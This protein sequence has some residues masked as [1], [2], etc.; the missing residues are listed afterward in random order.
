ML[1]RLFLM[2]LLCIIIQPSLGLAKH[3]KK[4]HHVTFHHLKKSFHQKKL[5]LHQSS[6]KKNKLA[7]RKKRT[8]V[9]GYRPNIK[10]NQLPSYIVQS[11]KEQT[12]ASSEPT[13][14]FQ[15]R[16]VDFVHKSIGTIRYSVYKLGGSLFDPTKGVY[17]LDC[18]NYVDQ[19]LNTAH[20]ES[21]TN[22]VKS[23]GSDKPNS[24]DYYNFFSYL[25]RHP[26]PYWQKINEVNQMEPGDILVVR[27]KNNRGQETGGHV[28][29]VM[30]KPTPN[31]DAY[32]VDVADSAAGPHSQDTRQNN[33]SGIGIG[34]LLLKTLPH[35]D[36][37]AALA[38]KFGAHWQTNINLAIARPLDKREYFTI[39][40]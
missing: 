30:N 28:M 27:Y 18:S 32:Q 38:W 16:L 8:Y 39:G 3:S 11:M 14:S 5:V 33:V 1:K 12:T 10:T 2:C 13:S 21:Y 9:S 37:P 29:I 26:Q 20:P 23:T 35:S 40:Y 34:T 15:Q 24:N 7:L 22:L 4:L 6:T 25:S 17:V 19:L 31:A 36:T